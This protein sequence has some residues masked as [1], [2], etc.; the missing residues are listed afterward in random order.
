MDSPDFQPGNMVSFECFA[1]QV[2]A[3]VGLL[4][5]LGTEGEIGLSFVSH[6]AQLLTKLPPEL[7]TGFRRS[8]EP[9]TVC[10]LIDLAKWLKFESWCQDRE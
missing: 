4:N 7:R 3:L 5:T 9:C 2:Q 6:V 10:T 8:N 1:L